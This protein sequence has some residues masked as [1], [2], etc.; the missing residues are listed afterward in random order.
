[1]KI[2]SSSHSYITEF[3]MC[4]THPHNNINN[5]VC[6]CSYITIIPIVERGTSLT[7]VADFTVYS[8]SFN[9]QKHAGF[10]S[11]KKNDI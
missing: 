11:E 5:N 8:Q 6:Y 3:V 2:C 9:S 1:M 4:W 10:I 7:A